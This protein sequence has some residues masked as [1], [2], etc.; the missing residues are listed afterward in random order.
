LFE[1][2]IFRIV[3][4]NQAT[5]IKKNFGVKTKK[6]GIKARLFVALFIGWFCLLFV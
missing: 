2:G 5:K 3:S 4:E 1:F 6:P